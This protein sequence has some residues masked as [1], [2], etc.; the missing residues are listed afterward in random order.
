M[1]KWR[2]I[3]NEGDAYWNMAIDEAMLLL[4][5][6]G[7]IPNT[8]RL[9]VFN[10]SAVTIGY[11]QRVSDAVNLDFLNE[12]KIP[13]TRRITGGG[14]VYHDVNGEVTYSVVASINDVA[15]DVLKSYEIICK[16]LVYAIGK[17]GL[18]AQFVPINDVVVNGKKISGSAQSRKKTALLQHGT[19]MYNT[20]LVTL[21]STLKASKEKLMSHG[22]KSILER[23]TT[24][25]R[26]LGRTVTK[27]ETI[28]AMVEGFSKALNVELEKGELTEKEVELAKKLVEK[29]K[30]K[31]WIF[32]R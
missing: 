21:A 27:E 28:E 30:S 13:F 17:F 4:K 10:P 29:Y 18:K 8:L 20:D 12:R 31:E 25:S 15:T 3:I 14:S 11:F 1:K 22:V 24:L 16:G 6:K 26:E 7:E 2:L 19:L 23:V 9:Y 32:K 5:D